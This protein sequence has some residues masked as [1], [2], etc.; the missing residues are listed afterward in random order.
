MITTPAS[1]I[2]FPL[3]PE[4]RMWAQRKMIEDSEYIYYSAKFGAPIIR[5][6][7]NFIIMAVREPGGIE[8]EMHPR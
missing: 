3:S 6:I 7:A 5:G 8:R 4:V 2:G 1:P